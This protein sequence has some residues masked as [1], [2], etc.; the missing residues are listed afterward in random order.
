MAP[1]TD[2]PRLGVPHR[3][4]QAHTLAGSGANGDGSRSGSSLTSWP[5]SYQP[6]V[7]PAT[8]A[9]NQYLHWVLLFVWLYGSLIYM[10]FT[11]AGWSTMTAVLSVTGLAMRWVEDDGRHSLPYCFHFM[12]PVVVYWSV[13]QGGWLAYY[14]FFYVFVLLPVLDHLV[15]YDE[16]CH[17]SEE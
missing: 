1:F 7:L 2:M 3:L 4:T 13:H 12:I 15:G 10:A 16:R 17:T 14:P 5:T 6:R 8:E 9:S 11:G